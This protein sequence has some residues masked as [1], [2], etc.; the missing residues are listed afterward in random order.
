MISLHLKRKLKSQ[1]GN[2]TEIHAIRLHRAISWIKAAEE[3]EKNPDLRLVSL[4]IAYN[5][6]YAINEDNLEALHERERFGDF[7]DKLID[8]DDESRLYNLLWNKYSGS[9]R[10]LIE[11]QYVYGPYWDY[12]RGTIKNWEKGFRQSIADANNA[13]S[14]QNVNY[15]LRI[16]LDRLYVLRNQI[17]HGGSTYSSKMNRSQVR[18]GGN[19][20]ISLLPIMIEIMIFQPSHDW[21]KIYYP[22]VG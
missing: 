7:V 8:F 6:L 5:S 10:M 13:L 18:D 4:W 11:N 1:Q 14:K 15:L 20:L 19:I 17:V 9:V 22:P 12:Q 16:V 3:Q 21:G 2:I